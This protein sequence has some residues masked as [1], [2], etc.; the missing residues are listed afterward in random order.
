MIN[1]ID[2]IT[3]MPAKRLNLNNKGRIK[4]D[5]DADLTIFDY[6]QIIDK[7]TFDDPVK[8]PLGVEYVIVNGKLAVKKGKLTANNSGKVIRK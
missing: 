3:R 1:S 8:A 6:E 2:K 5:Y 7:A 4:K